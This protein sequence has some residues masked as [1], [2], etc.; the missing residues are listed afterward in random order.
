MNKKTS[1]NLLFYGSCFLIIFITVVVYGGSRLYLYLH[2]FNK[3]STVT[4]YE[5]KDDSE[6]VNF[7]ILGEDKGNGGK[8]RT[9]TIMLVNYTYK[10]DKVNI[11]SIPRDTLI[12]INDK[13][14]K[15]NSAHVYGGVPWTIEA[16]EQLLNVK[17]N[18]Y[19]KV[20]YAGFKAFIDAIGG[21]DMEI[22][23]DMHYD[24]YEQGLHIHFNKGE[25]VHLDGE[26]A[27]Q[28]F[29]WRK[30]NDGSGLAMGD[31]DRIENQHMFL[32]KVIDKLRDP[33]TVLSLPQLLSTLPDY[34]ET[35]M[36]A[37]D[38][39][40]YG[41]CI[42]NIKREKLDFVTIKGDLQDIEGVS[43]FIY[44]EKKNKEVTAMLN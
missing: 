35:N 12:N 13:N 29:R 27:E 3:D 38:L 36:T 4:P 23:Q 22:K 44:D 39:L 41:L 8:G 1:S 40:K 6:P 10:D 18:Y 7:L 21:I 15:I 24:D 28:F 34:I 42:K 37:K 43:Y 11:I 5:V 9:D 2:K 19:G 25:K 30:N 14:E 32:S 17:I 26:G 33:S 31:L 20:D 16:V